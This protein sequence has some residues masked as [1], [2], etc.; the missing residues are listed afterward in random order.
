MRLPQCEINFSPE[1]FAE[2]ILLVNGG[3]VPDKNFF[4]EVAQGRKI[5][6]VDKGIELC[7][8]NK[9]LPEKLIGDF[10]SAEKFSVDWAIKNK[11]PVERHPVDKDFTDLQL[12]LELVEKNFVLVTGAFGGRFDHLFSEIFTCA[13]AE[14]KICLADEREVI[15]FLKRNEVAGVKFFQKPFA[16]SLMPITEVCEGVTINNVRW[17]L[18]G[19]KLFQKIPNAISNRLVGDEVKIFLREGILAIYFCFGA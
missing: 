19:A 2:E 8:E 15:F 3:R 10:D 12:A 17:Q 1:V 4:L 14:Q 18:D 11:I 16:V 13:H 9:I 5:F 7:R 6:A